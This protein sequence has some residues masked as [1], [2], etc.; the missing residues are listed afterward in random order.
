MTTSRKARSPKKHSPTWD[1]ILV[2]SSD[3]PASLKIGDII[4]EN[5]AG[6]VVGKALTDL[7]AGVLVKIAS[8]Q[9]LAERAAKAWEAQKIIY[10]QDTY[11]AKVK[12]D[13]DAVKQQRA[14]ERF[15]VK[16][17]GR[18]ESEATIRSE[19]NGLYTV[20]G[21]QFYLNKG[22]AS[23]YLWSKEPNNR[24]G[25]FTL[26]DLGAFLEEARERAARETNHAG[27]S[28][29]PD[30]VSVALDDEAPSLWSRFTTWLSNLLDLS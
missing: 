15:L 22:V 13:K 21:H 30:T 18:E 10:A 14:K 28:A 27:E 11:I 17:L 4:A 12:A 20:A 9:T 1:P 23:F 24:N 25:V 2:S 8:P 3:Q 6:H 26:A 5:G 29:L 7:K 16:L 19:H